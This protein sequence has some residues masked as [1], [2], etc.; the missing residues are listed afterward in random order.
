MKKR[1]PKCSQ[2]LSSSKFYKNA[3][4]TLDSY[5]K[6]C[7]REYRNQARREKRG[8]YGSE[9]FK[10][11]T[12]E[13]KKRYNK[14]LNEQRKAQVIS[15]LTSGEMCCS[16]CGFD[17]IR[18]LS[19]DHID[20]NGAE[21]RKSVRGCHLYKWLIKNNF[22]EGFQVLCMNCQWIKRHENN[23]FTKKGQSGTT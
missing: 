14:N 12:K 2:E 11:T 8:Y 21:H 18:A 15:E 4:G 20:G 3:N 22:P 19:V 23:E 6:D 5:C 7:K 1:C 13:Y 9:K 16:L 10:K 17:D